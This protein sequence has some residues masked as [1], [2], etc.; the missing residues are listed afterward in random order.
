M[1]CPGQPCSARAAFRSGESATRRPL[2]G[3]GPARQVCKKVRTDA[4]KPAVGGLRKQRDSVESFRLLTAFA[5][6][7]FHWLRRSG[8][9]LTLCELFRG[10]VAEQ[11]VS[12]V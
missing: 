7:C 9:P 5:L 1:P 8:S 11:L 3:V 2:A 4:C 6:S 12:V 10:Q